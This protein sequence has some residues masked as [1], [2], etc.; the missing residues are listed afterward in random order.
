MAERKAVNEMFKVAGGLGFFEFS[1]SNRNF[2]E[3]LVGVYGILRAWGLPEWVCLAG[4]FHSVYGTKSFHGTAVPIKHR[5]EMR[6]ILGKESERLVY[7]F[8]ALDQ[9]EFWRVRQF[10]QR[11]VS[12]DR[13]SGRRIWVGRDSVGELG[14]ISVANVIEQVPHLPVEYQ[15]RSVIALKR[16]QGVANLLCTGARTALLNALAQKG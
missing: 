13:F 11:L 7:L 16:Y 9:D 2:K 4:L 14:N 8:C 5:K 12:R 1:H 10:G 15:A 6:A 3:H